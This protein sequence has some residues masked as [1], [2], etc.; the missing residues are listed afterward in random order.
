MF[1]E[2]AR[3]KQIKHQLSAEAVQN[4]EKKVK[5]EKNGNIEFETITFAK[6][7]IAHFEKEAEQYGAKNILEKLINEPNYCYEVTTLH[8][9]KSFN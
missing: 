9:K 6:L 7:L 4:Y 8:I 3:H 5:L 1:H 2:L